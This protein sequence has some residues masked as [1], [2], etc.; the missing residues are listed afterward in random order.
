MLATMAIERLFD[1]LLDR[2]YYTLF[3]WSTFAPLS[4]SKSTIPLCPPKEAMMRGVLPIC[5]M[6]NNV[7][8]S[9]QCAHI[10]NT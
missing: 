10:T 8:I 6:E 4:R 3:C 9:N 5:T 2:L 1:I 7:P